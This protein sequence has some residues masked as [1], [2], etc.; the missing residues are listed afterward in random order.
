VAIV[1]AL[2]IIDTTTVFY[3]RLARGQ[4]PFVGGRD[5]TTH[6][7]SYIGLSDRQVALTFT[8]FSLVSFFLAIAMTH[9]I[10]NWEIS[11]YLYFGLYFIGLFLFL[12][13]V[14]NLNKQGDNK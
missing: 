1:F 12:F 13:V 10:S 3:K 7:L 4:S 6:H 8:L 9:F 2:P 11:Y 14:A 5:H